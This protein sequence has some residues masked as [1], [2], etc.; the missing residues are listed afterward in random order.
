MKRV[1]ALCLASLLISCGGNDKGVSV[2]ELKRQITAA[3]N[4]ENGVVKDFDNIKTGE[5]YGLSINAIEEGFVYTNDEAVK[6][7][8]EIIVIKAKNK[9]SLLEIERVLEREVTD[10]STAWEEEDYNEYK[11][12]QRHILKSKGNYVMLAIADDNKEAEKVFDRL[13]Y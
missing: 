10:I 11:K 5:R 4:L 7:A 1:F 9:K 8:D 13:I 3:V 2:E 6:K 12:T